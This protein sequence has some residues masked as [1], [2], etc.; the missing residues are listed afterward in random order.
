MKEAVA[1][2]SLVVVALAGIVFWNDIRSVF[3]G[4]T[5]GETAK[6]TAVDPG[7]AAR[8]GAVKIREKTEVPDQLKE[9]SG[10][11]Y[12][13][14]GKFVCIQDEAGTLYF[15]DAASGKIE[16]EVKFSGKGDF[17]GIAKAGDL[18][19]VAR[20]DG[21]IFLVDATAANPLLK[22]FDTGLSIKDNIESLAFDEESGHL[23]LIGKD[24]SKSGRALRDM[25]SFDP[26]AGETSR[27]FSV[28]HPGER[29]DGTQKKGGMK[30]NPSGMDIHPDT[31]DIYVVDGPEAR[32]YRI[33][34]KG[35][36]AATY[37]L[38]SKEVP[39]VEG[40]SFGPDGEVFISTEAGKG[41][42]AIF[43]IELN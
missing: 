1:L 34:R 18:Y 43:R 16:K 22:E 5:K 11:V 41:A 19:Y 9:I 2:I 42:G 29:K 15:F 17:E 30:F 10:M 20:A 8:A 12:L 32:I 27:A 7:N 39:Q 3:S 14:D 4:S 13:G 21:R 33:T 35:E 23:L 24:E 38:D 31:G 25:F 6:T 40:I 37:E 36:I 26:A 28:N